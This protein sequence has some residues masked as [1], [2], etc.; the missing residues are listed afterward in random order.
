MACYAYKIFHVVEGIF[1]IT[2]LYNVNQS[3]YFLSK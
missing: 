1:N 2:S 3:S